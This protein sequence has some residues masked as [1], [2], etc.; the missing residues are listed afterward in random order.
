MNQRNAKLDGSTPKGVLLR[1]P[2]D[3]QMSSEITKALVEFHRTVGTIN[4]TA[5]SYTNEY[6]PLSEVL[7]V[8]TPALSAQGLTFTHSFEPAGEGQEPFLVCTL[9]HTSGETL[10]SKL[11]LVVAKGKNAVQDLG[12]AITYL[13][14]YTLLAMLGIVADVD[15]DGCPDGLPAPPKAKSAPAQTKAAPA[16]AAA[17]RLLSQQEKEELNALIMAMPKE[18]IKALVDA[19]AAEF[20]LEA[21]VASK[22]QTHQHSQF[23]ENYMKDNA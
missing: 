9:L 12:S 23:I 15:T 8:V 4:K 2:K 7:S 16:K 13:K 14:R 18:K 10:Q 20:K 17:E 1:G 21:P 11:P 3:T 19:F 22:I 6:A 5:K